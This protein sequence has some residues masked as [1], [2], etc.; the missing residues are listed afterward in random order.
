MKRRSIYKVLIPFFLITLIF[1]L[2]LRISIVQA[3]DEGFIS[4]DVPV[5]LVLLIDESGSMKVN[6]PDRLRV[7]AARLFIEL[8]QILTENNR[9]AVAGFGEVTNIY[10]EPTGVAMNKQGIMDAVSSIKSNQQYTDMKDALEQ[11]KSMLDDRIKKNHAVV[12]FLTDG[13]L[14]IDDIPIP[15]EIKEEASSSG[16]KPKPPPRGTDD[17]EEGGSIKDEEKEQAP[18]GADRDER[19]EEYL[20]EYKEEL[21]QLCSQYQEDGIKIFPIAFTSEANTSILEQISSIT[22]SRMWISQNA[23]DVRNV[24]LDIFKYIT[25]T[26]ISVTAQKEEGASGG[27]L[28]M[29]GYIRKAAVISVANE[30]TASPGISL[31]PPPENGGQEIE[32]ID[33]SS[34]AIR[35]VEK[36]QEGNWEYSIEGDLVLA[37]DL[38]DISLIDPLK[39]VYFMDSKVPVVLQLTGQQDQE[40]YSIYDDFDIKCNILYPGG[41][42]SGELA[43]ADNGIGIDQEAGDGIFSYEFNGTESPGEYIIEFNINHVPTG[44]SSLKKKIFT[45]TDYQP[46]KKTLYLTIENNIIAETPVAIHANLE[47]FSEGVFHY[48]AAGPSGNVFSGELFD[49]GSVQ[50]SDDAAGDGIYSCTI[51]DFALPGTYSILVEAGYTSTEGY[52]LTQISSADIEKSISIELASSSGEMDMG[53]RTVSAWLKITS[54][55]DSSIPLA[56]GALDEGSSSIVESAVLD[57]TAISPGIEQDVSV[58]IMLSDAIGEGDHT[59]IIPLVAEGVHVK[60]IEI[61]FSSQKG[62][63]GLDLKTL[64]GLI[65]V[66]LSLIPLIFLLYTI[67]NIRRMGISITHPRIIVEFSLFLVFFIAGLIVIFI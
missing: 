41:R 40:G 65:L 5:D 66:V 21:F 59:V 2:F 12:I 51:G 26:F 7:D 17:E 15:D 55:L 45:V 49:N 60:N 42:D 19:L 27:M 14:G 35:V 38:A 47:D 18:P 25:N 57:Q 62:I 61:S 53:S 4:R 44:A 37:L 23:S 11:V 28:E 31:L 52:E 16:E 3:D 50:D 58:T 29:A 10:I 1:S 36:P 30:Y 67:V 48:E 33:D 34:Y 43:L 6:D 24:Y 39:A 9:V 64:I 32:T 46:V 8:N 54:I 20:E 13:D 56:I 22:G 63:F